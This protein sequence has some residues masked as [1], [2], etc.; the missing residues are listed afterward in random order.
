MQNSILISDAQVRPAGISVEEGVKALKCEI[1]KLAK[2]KSETFSYLCGG[3]GYVWRSS[4]DHS[5]FLRLHGSSCIRWLHYGRGGD[6]A[7][8]KKISTKQ[9]LETYKQVYPDVTST[10]C[11]VSSEKD[12]F[13]AKTAF[14]LAL[15]IGK[16]THSYPLWVQVA[17]KKIVIIKSREFLKNLDRMKKGTRVRYFDPRHPEICCE[18]VIA[19]EGV[20]YSGAAPQIFV[21]SEE[22]DADGETPVFAVFWRP[23]EE[24]S[25][26]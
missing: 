17:K 19:K 6:V 22:Y 21:E 5:R 3:G 11:S 12:S 24:M 1:R 23:V 14:D 16:M 25:E 26:K 4:Y 2:T 10:T 18:G 9:L 8:A 7:M 13:S 20:L 15:K